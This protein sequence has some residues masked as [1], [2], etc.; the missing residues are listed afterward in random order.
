M[1]LLT[2]S[3]ILTIE[4]ALK[5]LSES[6]EKTLVIVDQS[7]VVL[8]TLSDGDIRKAILAGHKINES[9]EDLYQKKPTVFVEGTYELSQIETAFVENRFDVIPIVDKDNQLVK[10]LD[11]SSMYG[12]SKK[13]QTVQVQIPVVVM[14][15]GRGTRLEPFTKIL[16]KPLI[17]IHEKPVI[18]HILDK[19]VESGVSEFILSINYKARLMK[20]YFEELQ[21]KY[22]VSFIQENE[23]L[24]TA[25]YRPP[26]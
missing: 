10:I 7:N 16:P 3:P 1:N 15:G 9:I 22:S 21:P 18:E 24:G 19:F 5:Q 12:D 8:G 14:A 2:G 6:G 4:G 17:P 26:K 13:R 20:A 25:G 11:W 23:P